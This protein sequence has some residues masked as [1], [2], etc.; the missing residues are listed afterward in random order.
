MQAL[1]QSI[2][3]PQVASVAVTL[4]F[5]MDPFGNMTVFH[6]VLKHLDPK[7]RKQVIVRELLIALAILFVFLLLG[8]RIL[9]FLG[10]RPSAI[11]VAGGILLFTIAI[12]MVFPTGSPIIDESEGDPF[13]VPLAMPLVAGPSA[14]AVLLLLSASNPGQMASGGLAL[15]ISWSLAFIILYFSPAFLQFLGDRGLRALERLMGMLLIMIAV[16]M[17]LDGV[18]AYLADALG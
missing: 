18:A 15:L 16:Q 4:F 12:K 17:F 8:T 5:I 10:L 1:I 13:I 6:A 7:R 11:N 14:I 9:N 2:S 3:W